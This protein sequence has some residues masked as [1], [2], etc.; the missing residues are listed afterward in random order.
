MPLLDVLRRYKLDRL[1]FSLMYRRG[2]TPW[3]TGVSPPELVAAIEG[4]AKL[5]PGRALDIGCGTG[6]NALYLARHGWHA[7]GVDFAAP[8]IA[9]ARAKVA[10]AGALRGSVRFLQGD[11]TRLA[12]LPL[13]PS[14]TLVLDLGC[15]HGIPTEQRR[16]YAASVARCAAPGAVFLLYAFGPRSIAGRPAGITPDEVRAC[17]APAFTVERVVEGTD[18]SRGFASAW[19]WLRRCG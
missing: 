11:A 13:G 10:H 12:S 16:S 3:D 1:A 14:F 18:T 2:R 7:V 19:Y 15:F 8:A 6:T 4:A 17:F 9:R 5:P